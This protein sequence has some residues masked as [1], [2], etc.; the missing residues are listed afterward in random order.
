MKK[1]LVVY[2]EGLP[3]GGKTTLVHQ[4]AEL[5]PTI[6]DAIPEYIDR[7]A[8]NKASE[9]TDQA[10][11]LKNDEAKYRQARNSDKISLVDRGHLSTVL[12]CKAFEM[13]IGQR[14]IDV[15]DWYVNHI[16]AKGMLPDLYVHLIVAPRTTFARRPKTLTWNNMWDYEVALNFARTQFMKYVQEY[17]HV[18]VL[19]LNADVQSINEIREAVMRWTCGYASIPMPKQFEELSV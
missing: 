2:I 15:D 16:L 1:P 18:P 13:I 8:G 12:Y 11:F 4:T 19:E 9:R 7:Q 17:E 10:Y 3:G 6:F 5:Y 14:L